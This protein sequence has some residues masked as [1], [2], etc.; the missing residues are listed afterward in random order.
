MY[1]VGVT[2]VSIMFSSEESADALALLRFVCGVCV[3]T[4]AFRARTRM[5]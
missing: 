3:F 1:E 5:S 2:S 4:V